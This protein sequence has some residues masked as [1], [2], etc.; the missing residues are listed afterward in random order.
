M[1]NDN[2]ETSNLPSEQG[3]EEYRYLQG[4][5]GTTSITTTNYQEQV[6]QEMAGLV[7]FA[8]PITG[9]TTI[10]ELQHSAMAT[11][12]SSKTS[13]DTTSGDSKKQQPRKPSLL[14]AS[15][16]PTKMTCRQTTP[17]FLLKNNNKKQPQDDAMTRIAETTRR[18]SVEQPP[19]VRGQESTGSKLQQFL[20]DVYKQQLEQQ[21]QPLKRSNSCQQF[22]SHDSSK[23]E[24]ASSDF[25]SSDTAAGSQLTKPG[26]VKRKRSSCPSIGSLFQSADFEDIQNAFPSIDWATEITN[27]NELELQEPAA[28]TMPNPINNPQLRNVIRPALLRRSS[29]CPSLVLGPMFQTV[30]TVGFASADIAQ[31]VEQLFLG[32]AMVPRPQLQFGRSG[33]SLNLVMDATSPFASVDLLHHPMVRTVDDDPATA[34]TEDSL[35][36]ARRSDFDS[37][38]TT[39]R[40]NVVKNAD[41]L[42][43]EQYSNAN[44]TA[45]NAKSPPTVFSFV[46]KHSNTAVGKQLPTSSDPSACG[47]C[48][49]TAPAG[50]K[51]CPE[52]GCKIEAAKNNQQHPSPAAKPSAVNNNQSQG[53][54]AAGAAFYGANSLLDRAMTE[55]TTT[56]NKTA[57]ASA[58]IGPASEFR[59]MD[60]LADL[61]LSADFGAAKKPTPDAFRSIDMLSQIMPSSDFSVFG[62]NAYEH[63]PERTMD[64]GSKLPN[65]LHI[66]IM[67]L[68]EYSPAEPPMKDNGDKK[69]AAI[70]QGFG[71]FVQWGKSRLDQSNEAT[72]GRSGGDASSDWFGK[73]AHHLTNPLAGSAPSTPKLAPGTKKKKAQ[74]AGGSKRKRREEPEVKKYHE[75][76]ELDILCGRG[77]LCNTWKGNNHYRAVVDEAKPTYNTLDR[78]EK[79]IMSLAIVDRM[80]GEG[81]RFLKKDKN[82]WFEITRAAA[83]EKAAQ[84]LREENTAEAREEK[85]KRYPAEKYKKPKKPKDP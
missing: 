66:G 27:N 33:P 55:A 75:K 6:Q 72:V 37:I 12:R 39:K 59:S 65:T 49:A 67:E 32:S 85:R 57:T 22:Q 20:G 80:I 61:M 13:T 3:A 83:R 84:A 11:H 79:T 60:M 52:C 48:G 82:G 19:I 69:P 10:I 38:D 40:P 54:G 56:G 8:N 64:G 71:S 26:I 21:R 41:D 76:T 47:A 30:D 2:Y 34:K 58:D 51:F 4:G 23:Q 15:D 53:P 24:F 63:I 43:G 70:P 25:A 28:T 36:A 50:A 31:D 18:M 74:S 81:R 42:G 77:T 7:S 68:R 35:G 78:H 17:Y 16:R 62:N 44:E 73:Y 1:K 46:E 9:T 14:G 5:T 45:N 29:S